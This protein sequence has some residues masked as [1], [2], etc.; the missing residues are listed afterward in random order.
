[1]KSKWN[2]KETNEKPMKVNRNPIN[3]IPKKSMTNHKE[4][5]ETAMKFKRDQWTHEKFY[6]NPIN[7]LPKKSKSMILKRCRKIQNLKTT[8]FSAIELD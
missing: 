6:R 4:I 2:S 3:E 1:M 8:N 7:E 5:N